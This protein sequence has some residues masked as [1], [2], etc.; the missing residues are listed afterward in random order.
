M[1]ATFVSDITAATFQKDVVERSMK[2]PVLLDFWAAWC[3]PCKALSPVLEK[4]AGEH[5]GAFHLGKVDT[6]REQDLAYAF[7]V[8]GIP[9]CV[10]VDG[11]RPVDGFQGAL[12]E[13]DVRRFLQ[14]NGIEPLVLSEASPAAAA[15]PQAVD[16]NSPAARLQRALAAAAKGDAVTARAA[17]EGLAEEDERFD[18]AQRL[19]AGLEWLEASLN[20]DGPPAEAMLAAARA[21]LLKGDAKGAMQ[22]ILEAVAADK[23]FRAGLARKAMLLCFLQVGEESEQLDDYRRRLATLLY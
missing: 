20:P 23:G 14:K 17:L 22:H 10:L 4:I 5:Q 8:Q 11:G 9:Y 6:E 7:G 2:T 18:Q 16:P 12:P 19:R 21:K 13:A 1:P 15:P 3:G